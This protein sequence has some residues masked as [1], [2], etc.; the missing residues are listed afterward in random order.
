[1]KCDCDVTALLQHEGQ[2]SRLTDTSGG[3]WCAT[4]HCWVMFTASKHDFDS[5]IA[6]PKAVRTGA[7]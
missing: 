3:V 6:V 4:H 7:Q 2:Y 1:M 5:R